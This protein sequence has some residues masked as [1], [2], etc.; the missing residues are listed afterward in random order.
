M[1]NSKE[2]SCSFSTLLP[3]GTSYLV[4]WLPSMLVI[5]DAPNADVIEWH[6]DLQGKEGRIISVR[7]EMGKKY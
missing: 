1:V 6:A 5:F 4:T 7:S 2:Q 3:L